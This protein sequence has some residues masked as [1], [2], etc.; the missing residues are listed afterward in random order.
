MLQAAAEVT[1]RG[2]AQVTLLG[3]EE[4][5]R[6]EG[7]R[8]GLDISLVNV[9]Q[10]DENSPMFDSYVVRLGRLLIKPLIDAGGCTAK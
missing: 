9:V 3:R 5:I 2:L 8:L 6:A 4:I 10:P 7:K 1:Q